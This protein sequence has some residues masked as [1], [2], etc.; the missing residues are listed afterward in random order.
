MADDKYLKD[1]LLNFLAENRGIQFAYLPEFIGPLGNIQ[2][3]T[4]SETLFIYNNS[5]TTITLG[6]NPESANVYFVD[7]PD[8]GDTVSI[9]IVSVSGQPAVE[10]QWN[11]AAIDGREILYNI[12]EVVT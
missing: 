2:L 7:G 11:V 1:F 9:S 10:L 4:H 8:A 6:F 12:I 3:R 5:M